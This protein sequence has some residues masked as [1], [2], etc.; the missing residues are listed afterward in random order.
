MKILFFIDCLQ[1]GGKERQM[2][3]L[4]RGLAG[5]GNYEIEVVTM[6]P[7]IDFH[8]LDGL[9]IPIHTVERKSKRDVSVLPRL[10]RII[11]SF[12]PDIVHTWDT[13]TTFYAVPLRWFSGFRLVNG[14]IRHAQ[15]PKSYKKF[16]QRITRINYAFSDA[17]VANSEAGRDAY[18]LGRRCQVIHNG[19]DPARVANLP[20]RAAIKKRY[21]IADGPVVGM[22]GNF[23]RY[24]DY[25]T[26]IEAAIL[27]S[28]SY[29]DTFF[30]AVGNG[31][32]L[33]DYRDRIREMGLDGR[34]RIIDDSRN[35]LEIIPAFD[36]A[37]LASYS[38]GF[39][40]VV[41]EYM[42]CGKPVVATDS[43]GTRELLADGVTGY[44]CRV[45]DA[46]HLAEKTA[47][48]LNEPL[49]A[50][51]MGFTG[52]EM[53]LKHFSIENMLDRYESLYQRFKS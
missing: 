20:E 24:K 4:V 27:I 42:A 32:L 48:L 8:E 53:V 12:R 26:F 35:A 21:Q 13:M 15:D 52:R 31:P 10:F 51:K 37:V 25:D 44:L 43:G 19:F 46:E 5:H 50:E 3:E 36:V 9:N 16:E 39:P 49:V 38:E 18:R 30:I 34:F 6:K 29:P 47:A 17:I 2:V 7:E 40:N 23:T 33:P 11:R 28:S 14:S 22:V 41:M 45:R 1:T